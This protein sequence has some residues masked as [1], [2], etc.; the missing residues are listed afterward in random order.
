MQS[1]FSDHNGIKLEIK[2][3]KITGKL[4]NTWKVNTL[5]NNPLAK[6]KASRE[7]LKIY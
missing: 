5:L 7:I 3:R 2:H 1:M 6:V 4:I